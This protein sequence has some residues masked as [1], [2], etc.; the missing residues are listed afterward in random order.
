MTQQKTALI[1]SVILVILALLLMPVHYLEMS[2]QEQKI[3]FQRILVYPDATF[4]IRYTHSVMKTPVYEHYRT[5]PDGRLLLTETEFSSHGA[6][7]P[8]T[9][10]N[11]FEMTCKG[12]RIYDINQPFDFI[13]YRTA[14]VETG[15]NMT[16]IVGEQ[17]Y[18]FL[19]FSQERTPVRITKKR[20]PV[21]MYRIREGS[22][23]LMKRII[24][25]TTR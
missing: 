11:K 10:S 20:N 18:P 6:G 4:S 5:L 24:Q 21:G 7:L 15:A 8:E 19:S 22:E 14:P 1:L 16:L 17:E 3:V 12:F 23:W 13:V 9:N 25:K 2:H